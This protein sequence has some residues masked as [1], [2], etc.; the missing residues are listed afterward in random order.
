MMSCP[1]ETRVLNA[2][3]ARFLQRIQAGFGNL[4]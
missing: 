3:V 2:Q 1:P 4:G